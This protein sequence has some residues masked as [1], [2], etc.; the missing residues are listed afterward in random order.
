MG[1]LIV[2]L[3]AVIGLC[4]NDVD[5]STSEAQIFILT[6][7]LLLGRSDTAVPTSGLLVRTAVNY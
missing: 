2:G 7:Q 4:L 3:V 1:V 5:Y 6:S